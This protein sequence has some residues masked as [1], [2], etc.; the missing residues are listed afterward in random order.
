[1]R[2]RRHWQWHLDKVH[3]KNSGVTHNLWRA[4]DH[5]SEVLET[6]VMKTRDRKAAWKF[7]KKSMK[8]HGLPETI[9]T[10]RLRPDG[11]DP[12]SL[13]RGSDREM[14]RWL[15]NKAENPHLPFRRRERAMLRI[16]Q[17]RTLQKFAS[18]L[19][20]VHNHFQTERDLLAAW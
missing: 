8:R 11:A 13:G 16:R 6:V 19:A 2:A 20:L 1:M 18:V 7:L 10:D 3:V 14:G 12:K 5:E 17:M 4:V 9:A 15:N